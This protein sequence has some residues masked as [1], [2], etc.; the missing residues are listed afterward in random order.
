MI[1]VTEVKVGSYVMI[2]G[3]PSIVKKIDISKTGKH[4]ASKARIEAV[5]IIDEKK[6]V[7]MPGHERL[8][9]Q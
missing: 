3:A 8:E 9:V 1:N 7:V 6:I 4:G 2:D 5:G